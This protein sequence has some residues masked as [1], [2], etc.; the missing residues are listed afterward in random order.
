MKTLHIV[1]YKNS[2][3]TTLIS[4]W[5]RLLRDM[6]IEVAVLKHHGHGGAPD[7]P[8]AHTDTVQFLEAG[9]GTTV[10]SGGGMLQLIQQKECSFDELKALAAT[11]RPAVLFIEGYKQEVGDKL[12]LIRGE[13]D[14]AALESLQGVVKIATTADFFADETVLDAWLKR[15]IMEAEQ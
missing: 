3:K 15:W 11:S 14:R 5:I 1:G 12:V 9:A 13:E 10:V 6:K 2:G 7:L 4:H 8:P